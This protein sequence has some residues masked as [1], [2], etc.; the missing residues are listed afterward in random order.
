M[1]PTIFLSTDSVKT[2]RLRQNQ[3]RPLDS[4]KDFSNRDNTVNEDKKWSLKLNFLLLRK[5]KERKPFCLFPEPKLSLEMPRPKDG[6][7]EYTSMEKVGVRMSALVPVLDIDPLL[8]D[9]S[10]AWRRGLPA[11][12]RQPAGRGSSR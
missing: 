3:R 2:W 12:S 7:K 1:D 8:D 6:N 9:K 4:V 10:S 11:G 5:N